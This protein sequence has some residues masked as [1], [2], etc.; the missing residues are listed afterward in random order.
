MKKSTSGGTRTSATSSDRARQRAGA[1]QSIA[2]AFYVMGLG[3]TR[4]PYLMVGLDNMWINLGAPVPPAHR[5]AAGVPGFIDMIVPDLDALTT[6]RRGE[7]SARG[8]GVCRSVEDKHVSVT[9]P[10]GNRM[11]F[12][13]PSPVGDLT[14]G[15]RWPSSP[16]AP[17][18]RRRVSRASTRP[19]CR[20]L[21]RSRR[22][23]RSVARVKVGP[24][25]DLRVP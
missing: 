13:A 14:L 15:M 6:A 23:A 25:Q 2:T 17:R 5:R 18:P 9:C 12:Y 1:R 8:D 21:P 16:R 3:F 4:D 7:G 24:R 10:W 20:R 11:R 19:S 22:T